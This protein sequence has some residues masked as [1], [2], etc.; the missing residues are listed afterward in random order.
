M[1]SH[2]VCTSA[3]VSAEGVAPG[4]LESD[5]T[6]YGMLCALDLRPIFCGPKLVHDHA[7]HASMRSSVHVVSRQARRVLGTGF[8]L[9]LHMCTSIR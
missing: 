1:G 4:R 2:N 8:S 7:M 6:E 9:C 3:L 5:D